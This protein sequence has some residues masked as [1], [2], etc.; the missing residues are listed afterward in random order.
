MRTPEQLAQHRKWMRGYNRRPEVVA[1]RMEYNSRPEVVARRKEYSSRPEVQ[2]RGRTPEAKAAVA[3]SRAR[4]R[5]KPEVRARR[6]AQGLL[7]KTGFTLSLYE[8]TVAEQGGK[9]AVCE[10][11]L[12]LVGRL[13][14]D[15]CHDTE[16]PRVVLCYPCNAAEGMIKAVGLSP[17]EFGSR[18]ERYL[19]DPPASRVKEVLDL[20]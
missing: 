14:A 4:Y 6:R 7:K 16:S 2:A 1:R 11:D 17:S 13:A 12:A 19:A 5:Q 3:L 10:R 20:L 18:L 8:Q 15:H 9:C